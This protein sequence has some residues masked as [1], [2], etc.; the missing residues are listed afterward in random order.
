MTWRQHAAAVTVSVGLAILHTW[1]LARDVGGLSR[2]DNADTAL[3]TW[4]VS[5]VAHQLPRDPGHVFDAPIFHPERRTLAYSEHLLAQGAM[6]MPLRA[7]GLSPTA[8][9]NLLVLAGFTL[10]AWAMWC[11]VAGWTGDWAAGAVAGAAFAF[12]AH[13]LTRFAHLQTLH[14]EFVPVVLLAMDRL[15]ATPRRRDALLLGLG[16]VLV[17]LTS[18]YLLV[19][20]TAAV[21][22]GLAARAAEW[23]AHPRST[24]GYGTAG[25]IVGLAALLPVL[26]PY[27]IV[28]RELGL[29]RTL[30]DAAQF[31]AGW[32]DYLATGGRLHYALWSD[33]FFG[34]DALFPG[35]AVA[36][37]V[38]VAPDRSPT[39]SRPH[40]HADRHRADRPR[41]LLR[42]GDAV[43]RLAVRGVAAAAR[44]SRGL[45]LGRAAADRRRG[46]GRVRRRG[47]ARPC[48]DQGGADVGVG[49]AGA[50]HARGR[51]HADGLHAD[52]GGACRLPPA[53]GAAAGGDPGVPAVPRRAVQ[54]ERALSARADGPLPSDRGRLQRV[55][56]AGL[57]RADDHAGTL[58]GGRGAER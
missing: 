35:L 16:L 52:A 21:V 37:L 18:I 55:R 14:L 11:L 31:S 19:F 10:S 26:W 39:P 40:A 46:A 29:E 44:D 58:S 15:A 17:G 49:A 24:L 43:L 51:P 20:I 30:A 22:V 41:A 12:N 6:A 38:G 34:R 1:P 54:P 48:R 28:N 5:W 53:G 23:R 32:R 2:L 8:T 13:L 45:A 57:H 9:Y 47:A 33:R 42:S 25:I 4:I 27:W 56:N 50:G 7:A 36:A 3:N